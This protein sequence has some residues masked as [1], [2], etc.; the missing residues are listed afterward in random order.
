MF[1]TLNEKDLEAIGVR[2]IECRKRMIQIIRG[3]RDSIMSECTFFKK[4]L[5][6]SDLTTQ[7]I[8]G[9]LD[10]SSF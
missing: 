1:S 2:S 5:L 8:N 10:C 9:L 7:P 6:S 3:K 4:D